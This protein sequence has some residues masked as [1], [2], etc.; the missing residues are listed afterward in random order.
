MPMYFVLRCALASQY[1][2]VTKKQWC[3]QKCISSL[4]KYRFEREIDQA[5]LPS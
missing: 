3:Q 4:R 2:F 5:L 1:S